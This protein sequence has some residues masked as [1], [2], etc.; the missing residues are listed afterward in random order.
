MP[1]AAIFSLAVHFIGFQMTK[2]LSQITIASFLLSQREAGD[3]LS[4]QLTES[5]PVCG[6]D[7]MES[8]PSS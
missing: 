6:A 8:G 4:S 3:V 1:L 2:N 5:R 7:K